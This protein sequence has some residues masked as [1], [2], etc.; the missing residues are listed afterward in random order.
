MRAV[1]AF[2][3]VALLAAA[4]VMA[5][6]DGQQV[7]L[8]DNNRASRVS[9]VETSADETLRVCVESAGGRGVDYY[10]T[11]QAA[12]SQWMQDAARHYITSNEPY[13]QPPSV[14]YR[15]K[16]GTGGFTEEFEVSAEQA[17][18][19]NK[20]FS[21]IVHAT[22]ACLGSGNACVVDVAVH[23]IQVRSWVVIIILVCVAVAILVSIAACVYCC[24]CKKNPQPP[25]QVGAE[26]AQQVQVGQPVQGQPVEQ[27][28]HTPAEDQPAKEV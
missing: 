15:S 2:A 13:N 10:F 11:S 22:S 9:L 3:Y 27:Q 20:F 24:C 14:V 17:D 12:A 7:S 4:A 19:A 5:C 26:G 25:Q 1:T 6:E 8:N 18:S 23:S 28:P 21:V 16:I